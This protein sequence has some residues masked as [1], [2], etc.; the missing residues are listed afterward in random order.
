MPRKSIYIKTEDEKKAEAD[1]GQ[2]G[3]R[4]QQANQN[5]RDQK[6]WHDKGVAPRP[7]L[8]ASAGLTEDQGIR[9]RSAGEEIEYYQNTPARD[10]VRAKRVA[11]A[12]NSPST[13]WS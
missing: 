7:R 6:R 5:F 2:E 3:Y 8:P 13:P 4:A 10:Q 1:R 9:G 11:P 12:S